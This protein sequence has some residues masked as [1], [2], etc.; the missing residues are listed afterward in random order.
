MDAI[1]LTVEEKLQRVLFRE[2]LLEPGLY[3]DVGLEDLP[4]R[5]ASLLE[6]GEDE[7]L[8]QLVQDALVQPLA[9]EQLRALLAIR[10][11]DLVSRTAAAVSATLKE[12]AVTYDQCIRTALCYA[13]IGQL[14]HVFSALRAASAKQERWARHHYLYGIILALQG[15]TERACWELQM[16]AQFEPFDQGLERIKTVREIVGC[17]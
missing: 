8:A 4:A 14:S 7:A 2:F 15:N 3:L 9:L 10:D 12:Q 17:S 6:C 13:V 5:L 11:M 16:A 1:M